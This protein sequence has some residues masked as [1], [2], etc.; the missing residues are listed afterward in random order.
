MS[1]YSGNSFLTQLSTYLVYKGSASAA[2]LN[3]TQPKIGW[4]F[5][6][7]EGGVLTNG[8]ITVLP[9]DAIVF[10]RHGW[11]HCN[12]AGA[13]QTIAELSSQ[14]EQL[15]EEIGGTDFS[16][17]ALK[18][19]IPDVPTKTS[20][21]ENDSGFLTQHQSLNDYVQKTEL[22][23]LTEIAT[24]NDIPTKTSELVNDSGFSNVTVDEE[25]SQN[26]RNAI[27][28]RA[29]TLALQTKASQTELD[30]IKHSFIPQ[31]S[32][33]DEY[34]GTVGD[35]VQYVG[36]DTNTHKNGYFYKFVGGEDKTIPATTK[37][38]ALSDDWGE[39]APKGYYTLANGRNVNSHYYI[40][41]TYRVGNDEYSNMT[42]EDGVVLHQNALNQINFGFGCPLNQVG[43]YGNSNDGWL[44]SPV[45]VGDLAWDE[46]ENIY[47]ITAVQIVSGTLNLTLKI[48]RTAYKGKVKIGSNDNFVD[49]SE[50]LGTEFVLTYF[51]RLTTY[52]PEFIVTN[53]DNSDIVLYLF[54]KHYYTIK[55]DVN[56]EF[57]KSVFPIP[58][59]SAH[60]HFEPLL[61]DITEG[62]FI[63]QTD[64][65]PL[66]IPAERWQ[67]T[68]VQPITQSVSGDLTMLLDSDTSTLILR[69]GNKTLSAI[70]FSV[71]TK[72]GM[73]ADVEFYN[74]AEDNIETEIPYLKFVFNTESGHKP[75]RV[76]LSAL[77]ISF[78]VDSELSETS[79]NPIEN[80]TVTLA[81]RGKASQTELDA[82]KQDVEDLKNGGSGSSSGGG[83]IT[84]DSE[85]STS[86]TNPVQNKVITTALM[87]KVDANS[88]KSVATS[89]SYND[90]TDKPTIPAATT[91]DSTI[92]EN[93]TNPVQGGAIY[94][95][96]SGKQNSLTFDNTPTSN[97][98]NPCTSGG[99]ATALS[100]K[101]G[102]GGGCNTIIVLSQTQYDNLATKDENTWYAIPEE[103]TA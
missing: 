67:Q 91:V 47:K 100:G 79:R 52:R 49:I 25:L 30:T 44:V 19:E 81:L 50:A 74:I 28:N 26:S 89:G 80:K 73:L 46:E 45:A 8:N 7:T 16:Q 101:V 90:L 27:E 5:D 83:E 65:E 88:L 57:Y 59:N 62:G 9:G 3:L 75:I 10:L 34:E 98:N 1:T 23:N 93:G 42:T 68:N 85:L 13:D 55:Q 6:V 97:S 58:M 14:F 64:S 33:L 82:V 103:T 18:T 84:V 78:A 21:L 96:L 70:D 17:F 60:Y 31:V 39:N 99:I 36:N 40:A 32:D 54:A 95:A 2:A 56:T 66:V 72:D 43:T 87:S 102:N 35:V 76:S 4:V 41:K 61:G 77:G 53:I 12:N 94:T 86:S 15:L 29:V 71:F 92:T 48:W 24:K 20:E 22:P 69:A 11:V 51:F 38:I 63:Q 37:Y